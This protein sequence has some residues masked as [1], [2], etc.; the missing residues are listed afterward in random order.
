MTETDDL[1]AA[2]DAAAQRW[3]HLSRPALL[4]RLAMEGDRAARQGHDE[5]RRRRLVVLRQNSGLLTG[6][7]GEDCLARLRE[8]WPE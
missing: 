2:L 8:D 5:R 7:Y 1:A 3:P 4:V 6:A